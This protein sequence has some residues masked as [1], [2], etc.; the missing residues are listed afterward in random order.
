LKDKPW[1]EDAVVCFEV[2]HWH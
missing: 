2:L 1:K